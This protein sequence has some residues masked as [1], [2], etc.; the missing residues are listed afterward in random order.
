VN[1][2]TGTLNGFQ[3]REVTKLKAAD[4]KHLAALD[5]SLKWPSGLRMRY[6]QI[7]GSHYNESRTSIHGSIQR[8]GRFLIQSVRK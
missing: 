3:L 2:L 5:Q 4:V 7:M 6:Q 8:T 1:W